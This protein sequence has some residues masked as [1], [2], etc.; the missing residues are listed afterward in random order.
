MEG[1]DPD[2]I[3]QQRSQINANTLSELIQA[4]TGG[5]TWSPEHQEIVVNQYEMLQAIFLSSSGD[6]LNA[7]IYQFQLERDQNEVYTYES[8]NRGIL[9]GREAIYESRDYLLMHIQLLQVCMHHNG[10]YDIHDHRDIRT[11]VVVGDRNVRLGSM[12]KMFGRLNQS[13][14]HKCYMLMYSIGAIET[15]HD[16]LF[17]RIPIFKERQK[18]MD[19]FDLLNPE[20]CPTKTDIQAVMDHTRKCILLDRIKIRGHE[21]FQP[22]I[23]EHLQP[24][25]MNT[26]NGP[27]LVCDYCNRGQHLHK[28]PP[29][30]NDVETW[31][32]HYFRPKL[33]AV[34]SK[35]INTQSYVKV[36]EMRY[37]DA[38][39]ESYI[40]ERCKHG[41]IHHRLTKH[42]DS[43]SKAV[44]KYF[45]NNWSDP[46]AK[47]LTPDRYA[48]S[49][50]NGILVVYTTEG[51]R[52]IFYPYECDNL[53]DCEGA[54][55][56]CNAGMAPS[57]CV[58][59]KFFNV[60]YNW[61]AIQSQLYGEEN[62]DNNDDTPPFANLELF[63]KKR[64][65][66]DT[67]R[68]VCSVCNQPHFGGEPHDLVPVMDR[69]CGNCG[70]GEHEHDAA[71][72]GGDFYPWTLKHMA[73]QHIETPYIDKIFKDQGHTDHVLNFCLLLLIGRSMFETNQID[74]W[75]VFLNI[76]GE[77]GTGKSMLLKLLQMFFEKQDIAIL[78]NN[79]QDKFVEGDLINKRLILG[80]EV[81]N[82]LHRAFSRTAVCAF[83]AGEYICATVKG[84]KSVTTQQKAH[85]VLV[86]NTHIYEQDQGNS[87][88]RRKVVIEFLQNILKT[89]GQFENRLMQEIGAILTKCVGMYLD[90]AEKHGSQSFW[91]ICPQ[92]FRDVRERSRMRTNVVEGCILSDLIVFNP[93]AYISLTNFV[94]KVKEYAQLNSL[95][96]QLRTDEID[97][98]MAAFRQQQKPVTQV[99]ENRPIPGSEARTKTTIW[100]VGV[101]DS[102]LFREAEPHD[103]DQE[104][105]VVD[106]RSELEE[107]L[108]KRSGG[109]PEEQLREMLDMVVQ[110]GS[111]FPSVDAFCQPPYEGNDDNGYDNGY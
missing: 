45:R 38:T 69:C 29:Q 93:E 55:C 63:L 51:S 23:T 27:A 66:P 82:K 77:G 5:E 110:W 24:V 99:H 94:T 39:I 79:A 11:D 103:T 32:T 81:D 98:V 101:G 37:K 6:D 68:E 28:M 59:T 73:H 4:Y 12:V 74:T 52:P 43:T 54:E 2:H 72:C 3:R 16:E 70:K 21:L 89:D 30:Y 46:Y 40:N 53:E 47:H 95:R 61:R 97:R 76:K 34:T 100:L 50:L 90:V 49:F 106:H 44:D 42:G 33:R 56:C 108:S 62:D 85:L 1:M 60:F 18:L 8:N 57:D 64:L 80:P 67:G 91:N 58:S 87:I 48:F 41:G 10:W 107:F 22:K 75:Q 19:Q 92:Y 102:Q 13:I 14:S 105:T 26:T 83:A 84:D 7:Y 20:K 36:D 78:N 104:T 9:N 65:C 35:R 31:E 15:E 25:Y 71:E 109:V 96:S 17:D 88:H 111:T 86:S